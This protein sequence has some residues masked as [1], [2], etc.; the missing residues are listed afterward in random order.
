MRMFVAVMLIT[1]L[2]SIGATCGTTYAMVAYL[3]DTETSEDNVL[4]SASS[5]Q[6]L[7]TGD[8]LFHLSCSVLICCTLLLLGCQ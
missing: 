2:A 3:K 4:K 1:L 7:R 5:H 8:L 6:P